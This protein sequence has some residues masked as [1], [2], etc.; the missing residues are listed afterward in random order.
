GLMARH[1]VHN[2]QFTAF[3][4]G[5]NYGGSITAV[6]MAP[7]FALFG[8]STTTLKA[9]PIVM[10]AIAAVL[11][12]RLGRRTIGEPGATIAALAFWVWPTNYVWLSTKERGFYWACMILGL[13]FLLAVL[14]LVQRPERLQEWVLLGLLGG[15]G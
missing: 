1:V 10:S 4:W 8:S 2:H 11:V 3:Y 15:V 14:R 12:W 13:S 9:V 7:V 6:V 5:Q